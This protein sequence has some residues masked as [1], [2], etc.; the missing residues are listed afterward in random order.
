M[1]EFIRTNPAT[2]AIYA[3]IAEF[4]RQDANERAQAFAR[5]I[6]ADIERQKAAPR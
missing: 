3:Q 4:R 6:M 2:A 5:K 1:P